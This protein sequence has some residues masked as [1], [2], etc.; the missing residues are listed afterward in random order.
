MKGKE[1]IFQL[2]SPQKLK[3]HAKN[4]GKKSENSKSNSLGIST[5]PLTAYGQKSSTPK[6]LSSKNPLHRRFFSVSQRPTSSSLEKD[7]KNP[8]SSTS[9]TPSKSRK[10]SLD[11]CSSL[12]VVSKYFFISNTGYIPGNTSKT[13]QDSYFA[14]INFANHQDSYLFGVFD[15]HGFYGGEVSSFIKQRLPQLL[16]ASPD[17]HSNP[18]RALKT[19]IMKT[20]EELLKSNLDVKFSGSTLNVVL[21][22]GRTLY[23]ANVG[24]SR[25][26]LA[27]QLIDSKDPAKNGKKWMAIALSR[28]HKPDNHDESRRIYLNGGRVQAYQ[29]EN[30]NPAGPARVWLK[31]QDLPG[32]AMS[33]SLGDTVAAS[34]GVTCEAEVASLNLTP[35][36]KFIVLGSDGVFEFISNEEIVKIGIPS[37]MISDCEGV[38]EAIVKEATK[39]WKNEEDVI[40]D[41]TALCVFLDIPL[42]RL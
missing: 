13:N 37:L 16:A 36:D 9:K 20:N 34:V 6:N 14:H 7:P 1:T 31:N 10:F 17:I 38:C 5:S 22:Q 23:C 35:E 24:D 18:S 2:I 39:R 28:D 27:R 32:L 11:P 19:S 12:P 21:I 4:K 30:G 33:R 41:I 42:N 15:G 3:K 29:D 8:R 40:D 25:S 26:M